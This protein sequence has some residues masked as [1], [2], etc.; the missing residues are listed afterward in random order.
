MLPNRIRR[1]P[2][3]LLLSALS[4]SAVLP[5]AHPA[6]AAWSN[7]LLDATAQAGN[8]GRGISLAADTAGQLYAAYHVRSSLDL[9]F[10]AYDGVR[11]TTAP[12]ATTGSVGQYCS[13]IVAPGGLPAIAYYDATNQRLLALA[14]SGS[15]WTGEIVDDPPLVDVGQYCSLA[16]ASSGTLYIAYYDASSADLKLATRGPSPPWTTQVV[17]S[18]GSVGK[19]ASIALVGNQ[20]VIAYF[21][22]TNGSLK[23]ATRPPGAGW[24]SETIDA[25]TAAS[26][27]G[28]YCSLAVG[29]NSVPQVSYWDAASRDLR[30]ARRVGAG[31][32]ATETVDASGDVGHSTALSLDTASY[33][34][35]AYYD[36]TNLKL[37]T[38]YFDGYVW[39]KQF[40]DTQAGRGA[41]CAIARAST[42]TPHILYYDQ[43]SLNLRWARLNDSATPAVQV[44]APNGGEG[45]R[46]GSNET[47]Q[48][49]ATDDNLVTSV[50]VSLARDGVNFTETL[51]LGAPNTGQLGWLVTTPLSAHARI[52]V[53]ARDLLNKTASDDSDGDFVVTD[54]PLLYNA[55]SFGEA[56]ACYSALAVEPRVGL[57]TD[58]GAV[59]CGVTI[60]QITSD[61]LH[62]RVYALGENPNL[63]TVLLTIDS[64]LLSVDQVSY[65]NLSPGPVGLALDPF[66]TGMYSIAPRVTGQELVTIDPATGELSS[67]G[68]LS[69]V[70]PAQGA[71]IT[72]LAFSPQ[73]VL[74]GLADVVSNEQTR[75][76][77]IDRNTL[78][79]TFVGLDASGW[80]SYNDIGFLGDELWAVIA[81]PPLTTR[82]DPLTGAALQIVPQALYDR[83]PRGIT[84]R[85]CVDASAELSA[86]DSPHDS[87]GHIDLDWSA[88]APPTGVGHYEILRSTDPCKLAD[89]AL[90]AIAQV[91]ATSPRRFTDA[92]AVSYTAYYFGVR[93]VSAAKTATLATLYA[94]PAFAFPNLLI[95]EFAPAGGVPKTTAVGGRS[96]H[97]PAGGAAQRAT[98]QGGPAKVGELV[99]IRNLSTAP[100][101][102]TGFRL[103][104]GP[105]LP[106]PDEEDL[107]GVIPAGG[108]LVHTL[109]TIDLPNEGGTL[110]LLPPS[111]TGL[112][113]DIVGYGSQGG[114]PTVP[115]GFTVSRVEGTT[116]ADP[117]ADSFEAGSQTFGNTNTV[118]APA[119]GQSIL[120]NEVLYT[121]TGGSD[122]VELYNPLGST[123]VLNQF[124]LSDGVNFLSTLGAGLQLGPGQ[125]KLLQQGALG[126]FSQNLQAN[127]LYLYKITADNQYQRIDQLG[128]G[129]GPAPGAAPADALLRVPDGL[130]VYLGNHGANW[131]DC[132][133]G[134]VL[135]YG[136]RT[137]GEANQ[138]PGVNQVVV[139]R[140]GGGDYLTIGAALAA[141]GAGTRVLVRPGT[142]PE[143]VALENGV[144][145]AGAGGDPAAVI[146]TGA[147][148]GSIVTAN[149]V[150]ATAVLAGVT[151]SGRS[152]TQGAGLLVTNASPTIRNVRFERNHANQRGG[153]A[154]VTGGTPSFNG[155]F[156]YRNSADLDGGAIA[157]LGG[158]PTVRSCLFVD[159]EADGRGGALFGSAGNCLV[160]HCVLDLNTA[161]GNGAGGVHSAGGFFDVAYTIV[162]RDQLGAPLQAEGGGLTGHLSFN[163][164]ALF[165]H[166]VWFNMSAGGMDTSG[167]LVADPAY[168]QPLT[169]NYALDET[170]PLLAPAGF[171]AETIGID[172][173]PCALILTGELPPA[174]ALLTRLYP[175]APNPFNPSTVLRFDLARAGRAVLALYDVRGRGVAELLGGERLPAGAHQVAW[176][177]IDASGRPVASGVYYLR[178]SLDGKPAG[179]AQRLV[180]LK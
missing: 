171:C 55:W 50:D 70:P 178:L 88:Y 19:Y 119:L 2:W 24:I 4:A 62:A 164:G 108:L 163:C 76:Y 73:G 14:W 28:E 155:C 143:S 118:P 41:N 96:N 6:G 44:L 179:E 120:L 115:A 122:Y 64:A 56:Q 61:P 23:Y 8:A 54:Q 81:S 165:Q 17:A 12:L 134:T 30:Y 46:V 95:N 31:H 169:F 162:T 16:R 177:G 1:L 89:S 86:V 10:G 160:R 85:P 5:A 91:A 156:F 117:D 166:P 42:G 113:L 37:K 52:R 58:L 135:M 136:Q 111:G 170:S 80:Y 151:L 131:H 66:G 106:S 144:E 18:T 139:D 147:G 173:P 175:A 104:N 29:A 129:G 65:V 116:A 97:P 153:G 109:Q 40:A 60:R 79:A 9:Y 3:Q 47:I 22:A 78:V 45:W 149:G 33:P 57:A 15:A 92:T 13:L 34:R 25:G 72:M 74:Y 174:A 69:F 11:W 168:C 100:L 172:G 124:A 35:I 167:V 38:A 101:D 112:A 102:L 157:V 7:S 82:F 148:V 127:V 90:P 93:V 36:A 77:R 128:W 71:K 141:V 176:T 48:W 94:G 39:T 132:G 99:E 154:A 87:G 51:A 63:A 53:L 98:A 142:Y 126:S 83:P 32:W 133:G 67:R 150:D 75:L 125:I 130:A 152:A 114:A 49:G 68:V 84:Q 20:P 107:S 26:P 43:T 140:L 138:E 110:L 121:S 21:D 137:P 158:S 159:N 161:N 59:D 103:S 146:I 105:G 123:A 27:M 145:I 180:L